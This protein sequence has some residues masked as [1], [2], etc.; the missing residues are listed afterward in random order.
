LPIQFYCAA[1]FLRGAWARVR[2]RTV[3]MDSLVAFA[4]LSSFVYSTVELLVIPPS[5]HH[6]LGAGG[7]LAGHL[8][9]DVIAAIVELILVGRWVEARAKSHAGRALRA[10]ATLGATQ[11]R[12]LD[13]SDPEGLERLVAVEA[14]RPGDLLRVRPGDKIPVDGVVVDG[15]SSVDES[16]LTG[17]SVPVD[18]HPGDPV[19][20]ATLNANGTVRIRVCAV[21]SDTA[22]ARLVAL[23]E[24]AQRAKAPVQRLADRAA[25]YFVP[26]VIAVS[27]ATWL[28]WTL[29]GQ[30]QRGLLDGISVLIIACPCALGLATPVAIMVGTGRG[31]ELGILI[32]GAPT[33]ER[34]QH[35]DAMVL[36]KTGT[37][38]TGA[39]AVADEWTIPGAEP[40]VVLSLAASAEAASE[41]PIGAAI[42][43]AARDRGLRMAPATHFEA[44]PGRGVRA[45]VAGHWVEVGQPAEAT[46]LSEVGR[47]LASWSALGRTAVT[48]TVD[49]EVQ[50]ALAVSEP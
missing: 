16:M 37:V 6:A 10:L 36:D 40:E 21:G 20:G 13:P 28:A 4:T 23:V 9:F 41:H 15:S 29:A 34:T 45:R 3:N 8:Q 27:V 48:V 17:E 18:K 46:H 26:A 44:I 42:T 22:F 19:T 50:G 25:G 7:E 5:Y 32:K 11:A 43:A 1:P 30:H 2:A 35:V 31:A 47:H 12:L 33:L 38:T 14:V 49:G 39:M 24:Q